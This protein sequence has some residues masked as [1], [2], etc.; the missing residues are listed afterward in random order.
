MKFSNGLVCPFRRNQL[1]GSSPLGGRVAAEVS[2]SRKSHESGRARHLQRPV[3]SSRQHPVNL[4]EACAAESGN[5]TGHHKCVP[6][7]EAWWVQIQM[8]TI[9]FW[10]SCFESCKTG[11]KLGIHHQICFLDIARYDS[12]LDNLHQCTPW[13]IQVKT[14]VYPKKNKVHVKSSTCLVRWPLDFR[15]HHHTC[16][17]QGGARC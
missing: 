3:R 7:K 9:G 12:K 13:G 15:P 2:A 8:S 4:P 1:I 10:M 5:L 14:R 17:A 16:S 11:L 6:K